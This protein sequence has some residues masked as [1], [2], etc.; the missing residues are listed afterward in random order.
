MSYTIKQIEQ[1]LAEITPGPW[2]SEDNLPLGWIVIAPEQNICSRA[3]R[4]DA[5]FIAA[6]PGIVRDL[7]DYVRVRED[8]AAAQVP[9]Y[10]RLK[11]LSAGEFAAS[12]LLV[13][14]AADEIE[15]LRARVAEL[16]GVVTEARHAHSRQCI[17]SEYCRE[18]EAFRKADQ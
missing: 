16:E 17:D 1:L 18:C 5:A 8:I 4:A 10:T 15:R 13:D 7:L 2:V 3:D 14:W 11:A 12:G 9:G 6:A